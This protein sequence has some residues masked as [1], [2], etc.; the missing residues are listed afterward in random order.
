[1]IGRLIR[2]LVLLLVFLAFAAF[3]W[4]TLY[5]YDHVT[6]DGDT[7]P[8]RIHRVTGHADMLVPEEGW[9]PVE[10]PA[11]DPSGTPGDT[12]T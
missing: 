8:V 2:G 3:V 4:P 11:E 1:M 6:V 10:Q 5:R 12:R 7:Y 9:V